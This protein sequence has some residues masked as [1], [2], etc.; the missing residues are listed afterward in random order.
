MIDNNVYI[1]GMQCGI[2]V[3]TCQMPG[4][5]TTSAKLAHPWAQLLLPFVMRTQSALP[6]KY[7][8][9]CRSLW[10]FDSSLELTDNWKLVQHHIHTAVTHPS[11]SVVFKDATCGVRQ[12][13][14]SCVQ[15]NLFGIVFSGL[16]HVVPN[17][18]FLLLKGWVMFHCSNC[19]DSSY[20]C[21]LSSLSTRLLVDT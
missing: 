18:R 17:G 21:F 19:S 4:K 6:V 10:H 15:V 8:R 2:F 13:S 5:M 14:A 1:Q 7:L 11:L 9:G 20:V 16:I 3:N 12:H